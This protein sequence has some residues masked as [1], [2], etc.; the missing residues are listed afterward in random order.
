MKN[1]K[2]LVTGGAGFLGSHLVLELFRNG[3]DVT[4]YD[5]NV[6]KSP[7]VDVHGIYYIEDD[8]RK[9]NA[10]MEAVKD[11]DAVIH[12][13]SN[14]DIK[15]SIANPVNDAETNIIGSL[16][17]L[18]ACKK[19]KKITIFSSSA[20]IYGNR[21][22]LPLKEDS[23]TLPIS[24]YGQSKLC[25][26]NYFQMY[27]KLYG[28][29]TISLR[30]LNIAGSLKSK[31]VFYN[32]A[33]ALINDEPITINGTGDQTRD[34]VCVGDVVDAIMKSMQTKKWGEVY[35]IGTGKETSVNELLKM[36]RSFVPNSS[37]NVR[38]S[39]AIRGEIHRS[40]A[41]ITK[42]NEIL[43]WS[44]K[45]DLRKEVETIVKWAKN[46]MDAQSWRDINNV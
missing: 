43:G 5:H 28:V 9:P 27:N 37:N 10:V 29:K 19:Y 1:G 4:I 39:N 42:A 46:G 45:G 30:I 17:V 34:F 24:P 12:L 6:K 15:D 25:A 36:F 26:D 35:N 18:E 8:I 7:L 33:K 11:C 32:F 23:L 40:Y 13:A 20:S 31:G 41:D 22:S 16:N 2:V 44:P 14:V 21:P 38:Y 3:Y